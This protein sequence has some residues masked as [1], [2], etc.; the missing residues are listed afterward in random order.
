MTDL[1]SYQKNI[2]KGLNKSL[3]EAMIFPLDINTTRLVIFSD[4]HK[5]R[6]DEADDFQPSEPSY[7]AALEYYL[8][9]GHMLVV[10]GDVEELWENPPGPVLE[11]Y[12]SVLHK[13]CEFH[14]QNRYRRFWGNHDD[15][16]RHPDQVRKHLGKFFT[17]LVVYESMR[18]EFYDAEVRLGEILLVHGH[19]GTLVSDRLGWF[20]RILIRYI[21]RPIQR[22]LKIMPNTPATDWRLRCRHDI[23]MY[24][25]AADKEELV[26][27]AG[28]THN[29]I[30]PSS[31]R[32]SRLTEDYHSVK[33]LSVD[34]DE[35]LQAQVNLEFAKAEE[36]PTY[37][38][39]GCCCFNDGRITGIEIVDGEIRLIRWPDNIG[40]Q[41]PQ[42]LDR[43]DL[44][45]VFLQVASRT[46]PMKF[47]EE[48]R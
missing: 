25:W 18:L 12:T 47:P 14:E 20:T 41:V 30:F 40:R 42:V 5:G 36:K 15:E 2:N 9:T 37:F 33:D 31:S 46:A 35:V 11:C 43:A 4:H 32:L 23:A 22:L 3:R 1:T 26:L 39:S 27:I 44:R 13:E 48:L 29:P 8:E 16:W 19:Q 10:L 24:N 34:P 17:D 28:H 21:W 6:G 7:L 45:K 38:N